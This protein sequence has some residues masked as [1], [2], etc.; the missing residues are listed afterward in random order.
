LEFSKLEK[1]KDDNERSEKTWCHEKKKTTWEKITRI[2]KTLWPR[3]NYLK[4]INKDIIKH[5]DIRRK[6]DLWKS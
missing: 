5:I 4:K 3:R 6:K 2:Q 1:K